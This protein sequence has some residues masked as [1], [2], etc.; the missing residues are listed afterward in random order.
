[1]A[2]IRTAIQSYE[3]DEKRINRS[4]GIPE[5]DESRM[6]RITIHPY[7]PSD[8]TTNASG[9]SAARIAEIDSPLKPGT[10]RPGCAHTRVFTLRIPQS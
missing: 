8:A 2:Q 1:M 4:R 6:E 3:G 10:D 7:V 5:L 9:L